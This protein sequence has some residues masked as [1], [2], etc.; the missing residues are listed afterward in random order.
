MEGL[1]IIYKAKRLSNQLNVA[2]RC[3]VALSHLTSSAFVYFLSRFTQPL[4]DRLF[5]P[6]Y[7]SRLILTSIQITLQALNL[8]IRLSPTMAIRR[9]ARLRSTLTPEV[10]ATQQRPDRN[11]AVLNWRLN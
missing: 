10:S 1:L 3:N 4:L 5:S 7:H 9:S 8:P 2:F 11:I 6:H